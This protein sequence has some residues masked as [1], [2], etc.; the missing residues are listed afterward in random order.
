MHLVHTIM[1]WLAVVIDLA[2]ALIMLWAFV[3]S[4]VSVASSAIRRSDAPNRFRDMQIARCDL[5]TR[6]VFALELMIVSDLLQTIISRSIDDLIFLGGLV[7]IRTTIAYFLNQEIQEVHAELS[8]AK[9]NPEET[10][11]RL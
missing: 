6:L 3:T 9:N 8:K 5:G 11:R 7:V 2:G 10:E 4:F 1:E